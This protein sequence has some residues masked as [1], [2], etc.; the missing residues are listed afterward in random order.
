MYIALVQ[1]EHMIFQGAFYCIWEYGDI[2]YWTT[3][4]DITDFILI[5]LYH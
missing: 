4:T 2:K 1:N 5:D 3:T